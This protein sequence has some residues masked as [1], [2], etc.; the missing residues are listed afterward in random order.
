MIVLREIRYAFGVKCTSEIAVIPECSSILKRDDSRIT[1][2]RATCH[3]TFCAQRGRNGEAVTA[4]S[5]A[6]AGDKQMPSL[7]L[8]LKNCPL[9]SKEGKSRGR[10]N[11]IEV[12]YREDRNYNLFSLTRMLRDEWSIHRNAKATKMKKKGRTCV[13]SFKTDTTREAL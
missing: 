7:L 1:D 6:I 2:S 4:A 11:L 8:D 12:N 3:S 5:K 9:P 13:F 10:C